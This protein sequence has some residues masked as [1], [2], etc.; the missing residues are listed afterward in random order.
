VKRAEALVSS[1]LD[2]EPNDPFSRVII[3][4]LRAFHS[5]DEVERHNHATALDRTLKCFERSAVFCVRRHSVMNLA[6]PNPMKEIDRHDLRRGRLIR[7][8]AAWLSQRRR[9]PR[10]SLAYVM[11]DDF[12]R[13]HG[14]DNVITRMPHAST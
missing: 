4:A 13:Q 5:V 12:R 14:R 9:L 2:H 7:R 10:E 1:Q 8:R 6:K 11:I 3:R